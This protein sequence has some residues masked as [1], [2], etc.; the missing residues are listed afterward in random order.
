MRL[1]LDAGRDADEHRLDA[2]RPRS[3]G[4]VERVEDDE[5]AGSGRGAQLVVGLVVAVEDDPLAGRRPR[6]ARTR[7]RPRVETSAPSPS[8]GEQPQQ[9]DVRERLRPVDDERVGVHCAVRARAR[10]N[11]LPAVDDERRAVLAGERRRADAADGELAVLDGRRVGEELDQPVRALLAPPALHHLGVAGARVRRS[12]DQELGAL[13]AGL[14]RSHRVL[15][16]ADRVP[17][18]QVLDLVL[19]L[20]RAL[21][22][23]RT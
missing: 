7:A 18:L 9:R 11:G 4:F 13:G 3:G 23:T 19:D 12:D 17:L 5:C 2:G 20:D 16:H 15:V 8:L 1:G 22:L 10:E 14:E 21:P 6:A